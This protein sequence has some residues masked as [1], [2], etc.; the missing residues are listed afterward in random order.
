MSSPERADAVHRRRLPSHALDLL[1]KIP[2][3]ALSESDR[4]AYWDDGLHLTADGYD[5]MGGHIADGLL[6]ILSQ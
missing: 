2:F 5:W 6:R 1:P 3:H 4:D